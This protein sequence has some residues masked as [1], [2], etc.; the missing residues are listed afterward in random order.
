MTPE[1]WQAIRAAFDRLALLSGSERERELEKLVA[2]DAELAREV[3]SLLAAESLDAGFLSSPA[4][5]ASAPA[6]DRRGE[7]IGPW[8][9]LSPLGEG[10][11]G[12]V[13]LA[14]RA[15][16]SFEK[17]VA[18]KFVHAALLSPLVRERFA[19]ERQALAA[20]EHPGIARLLDGGESA[21]GEPFLVL[22]YVEGRSLLAYASERRLP[23]RAR[24]EL[25]VQILAAVAH[26]HRHLVVHRDIK[27]SNILVT[28]AG[29]AKLLDFGVAKILVPEGS[30]ASDGRTATHTLLRALTPEYASPEQVLGG[31]TTTATD[32][33]SL[34]VVLFELLTGRRPYRVPTGAPEEWAEA[35]LHQEVAKDPSLRGDLEAIV[36]RAMRKAPAERYATA[37]AF[38]DDLRRFL[39]GRPVAARPASLADRGVKFVRRHK[40]AV[41]LAAAALLA[42]VATA[43]VALAQA[44]EARRERDRAAVE[45]ETAKSVANFLATLFQNS[46]PARTRGAKLTAREVLDQG[47]RR[48]ELDL[49]GQPAVQAR[50]LS[51]LGAVHRDL[52]LLDRAEPM[53]TKAL[54]LRERE[55]PVDPLAVAEALHELGT[56]DRTLGELDRARERLD[57]AR[58]IRERRLPPADP[59]LARTLSA[60]GLVYRL[61]GDLD[62]A[63][64][65]IERALAIA[66][67]G[68]VPGAEAGRWLNHL[69]L[70]HQDAGEYEP[71]REAF[72][73][74]LALLERSEGP[75]SPLLAIPLDNLGQTLRTIGRPAEALPLHQRAES[76]VAR[77]W[78]TEHSQHGTAL[79]SLGT[80]LVA[81]ERRDEAVELFERAAAVYSSALGAE[82][83]YVA[84]PLRNQAEALLVLDRPAEALPLF[85]K[86]LAI[87]QAAY[88]EV[89]PD[90]AQSLTDLGLGY[91]ALGDL[92]AAERW[93]REGLTQSIASL[94]PANLALAEARIF[95]AD[96][97]VRRNQPQ[98]ARSLYLEALPSMRAA[99]SATDPRVVEFEKKVTALGGEAPPG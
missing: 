3:R 40:A 49:E 86:A 77:T 35:A 68:P 23:T 12:R 2:S 46:D 63:R 74:S 6:A 27:P 54:E 17:L 71:A 84:W 34:G 45:A 92:E 75:E 81:L 65:L 72:A 21:A 20:L 98:E 5:A 37:D 30:G 19:A 11:M 62:R 24:V 7:R 89:H 48:I 55:R 53:L 79:N 85:E 82:H 43:L 67:T 1:R 14:R 8:E 25:F 42:I 69:G 66:R 32:I 59:E 9:L 26:A 33:Y 60:L 87:R 91:A 99:Y 18:V 15:D 57:R 94:E 44:A 31:A 88:G 73:E 58:E 52:G 93:L 50:L 28:V 13:F 61:Q 56:L 51:V 10:G 90:T 4:V 22:E 97:L 64:P 78:G 80:T 39:D 36:L 70:V 76:L 83:G 16:A 96:L 29:E 41:A 47:A 95:L 38:A